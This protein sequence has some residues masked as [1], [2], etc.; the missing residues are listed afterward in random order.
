[1]LKHNNFPKG[2]EKM[3]QKGRKSAASL[4]IVTQLE[5]RRPPPPDDLTA[6]QAEEWRATVSTMPVGWFG[7]ETYPLL[8]SY[9]RHVCRSRWLAKQLD[10]HADRIIKLEGGVVLLDKMFGMAEREGRAVLAHARSLRL[11]QQARYDARAAGRQAMNAPG[12]SYYDTME[13]DDDE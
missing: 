9:C 7:R 8:A 1:M 6:E 4:S 10:D 11:T 5:T 3:A 2:Q 12:G 13:L